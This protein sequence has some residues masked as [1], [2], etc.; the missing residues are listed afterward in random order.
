MKIG[1]VLIILL[2]GLTLANA[3]TQLKPSV[4]DNGGGRTSGAGYQIMGSIGQTAVGIRSDT[5]TIIETGYITSEIE[6]NT[7]IGEPK[8]GVA[9]P[10]FSIGDFYPNPFNTNTQVEIALALKCEVGFK[11]YDL[12][13]KEIY[14]TTEMRPAGQYLIKISPQEKLSSGTYLYEIYIENITKTGKISYIK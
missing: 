1:S 2:S 6:L 8:Q 14:R 11:L 4:T 5:G 13:G 9:P 12:A 7:E 3:Q 10:F